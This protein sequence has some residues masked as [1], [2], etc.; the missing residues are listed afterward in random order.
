VFSLWPRAASATFPCSPEVI[1]EGLA[2]YDAWCEWFPRVTASRVLI[3][4][5]VLAVIELDL[6]GETITLECTW[7]DR[8]TLLARTI[9]GK[10]PLRSLRWSIESA[11][12]GHAL[13]TVKVAAR[14]GLHLFRPAQRAVVS[15]KSHLEALRSW[16]EATGSGPDAEGNADSIF[17]LWETEQGLVCRIRGEKYTLTPVAENRKVK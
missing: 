14:A 3:R 2:D 12:T 16:M 4:E 13:V 9:Q 10:T 17:E 7:F 11:G 8:N 6:A 15:P 1:S 5:D